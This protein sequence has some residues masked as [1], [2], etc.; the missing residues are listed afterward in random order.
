MKC[1]AI[2]T[3]DVLKLVDRPELGS[4]VAR[5]EGSSPSIP[6]IVKKDIKPFLYTNA[7]V[8]QLDRATAF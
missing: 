2:Y 5:R 1:K 7:S 6:T 4:G 8:A 3:R